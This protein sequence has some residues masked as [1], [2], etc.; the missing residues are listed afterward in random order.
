[1][2]PDDR[3]LSIGAE[4]KARTGLEKLRPQR[5]SPGRAPES[6]GQ[7]EGSNRDPVSME[8]DVIA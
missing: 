6:A 4:S 7:G 8:I 1:M 5:D 3:R 2:P